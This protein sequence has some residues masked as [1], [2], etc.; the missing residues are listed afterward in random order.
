MLVHLGVGPG[1]APVIEETA[2][3]ADDHACA[4]GALETVD[5]DR[6]IFGIADDFQ[7]FDR[8]LVLGVPETHR[9]MNV[10]N[11]ILFGDG[12]FVLGSFAFHSEIDYRFDSVLRE[13]VDVV[14]GWIGTSEY[15][16]RDLIE[17]I[18]VEVALYFI[19]G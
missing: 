5:E 17:I 13:H 11:A 3:D 6:L 9:Y 8:I 19:F 16:V 2:V 15:S 4:I 7:G 1:E 12:F 10:A 14:I 18:E